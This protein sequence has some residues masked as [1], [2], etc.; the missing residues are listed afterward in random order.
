MLKC[1]LFRVRFLFLYSFGS[2]I[3]A[4]VL[5]IIYGIAN[6]YQPLP[7]DFFKYGNGHLK[8]FQIFVGYKQTVS[9]VYINDSYPA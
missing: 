7:E 3:T 2:L 9:N 4:V 6:N 5:G 1:T 8:S